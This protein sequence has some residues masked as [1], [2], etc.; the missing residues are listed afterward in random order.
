M[1][2]ACSRRGP[3]CYWPAG[4]AGEW[5]VTVGPTAAGEVGL[6][7]YAGGRWH[8]HDLRARYLCSRDTEQAAL[9]VL[10]FA[11]RT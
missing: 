3:F 6:L 4:Q 5:W 8:A 9:Q 11:E 7:V 2:S 10:C 1:L